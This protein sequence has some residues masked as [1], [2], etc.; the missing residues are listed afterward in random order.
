MKA[1]VFALAAI[2]SAVIAQSRDDLPECGVS[3]ITRQSDSES[4]L[5]IATAYLRR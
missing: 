1:S 4:Q 5:T 3:F 2:A